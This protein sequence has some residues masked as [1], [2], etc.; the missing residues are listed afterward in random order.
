MM[1]LKYYKMDNNIDIIDT[2]YSIKNN[3]TTKEF[4]NI[5]NVVTTY[6]SDDITFNDFLFNKYNNN[7][8]FDIIYSI[9]NKIT[10][11][12]FIK[13]NN[14]IKKILSVR[15]SKYNKQYDEQYYK[16]YYDELRMR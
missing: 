12:V 14:D 1:F 8:L 5:I 13:L 15:S 16:K 4:L 3:I 2:I 6:L 11:D 10:D 9:K 7:E